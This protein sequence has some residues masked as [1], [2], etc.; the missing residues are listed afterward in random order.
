VGVPD[1]A[2]DCGLGYALERTL[3]FPLLM[4]DEERE[5]LVDGFL[6]RRSLKH[7]KDKVERALRDIILNICHV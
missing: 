3:D 4:V 7:S 1:D 2:E 6:S 5:G